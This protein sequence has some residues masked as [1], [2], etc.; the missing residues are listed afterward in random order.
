MKEEVVFYE[1]QIILRTWVN[2]E[3]V[4]I[5][6]FPFVFRYKFFPWDSIAK[7]YIRKYHPLWEY[8]GWGIRF[9]RWNFR[10]IAFSAFGNSGLQLE[11][12]N[13]K[14]IL[15]GTRKPV[16]LEEVLQKLHKN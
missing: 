8:G 16:E 5:K 10:H 9:R 2:E 7:A 14:R 4:Y 3:G 12:T 1:K 15:I 11:L 13:G 6:M